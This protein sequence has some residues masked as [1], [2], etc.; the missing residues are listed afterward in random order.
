MSDKPQKP[1]IPSRSLQDILLHKAG[2][3]K[4]GD[5]VKTAGERMRASGIDNMPVAD[6]RRLVG[7]VTDPCTDH[8]ATG[9][10]HDPARTAVSESMDKKII[11]CFEDEDCAIALQRMDENHLNT[12]PVLDHDMKMVGVVSREEITSLTSGPPS[13]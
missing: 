11:Y 3:L 13:E 12:L 6:N 10:G 7:M 1:A 2:I 5:S 9:F 8:K 4:P